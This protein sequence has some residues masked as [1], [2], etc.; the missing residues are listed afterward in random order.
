MA[1]M[2]AGSLTVT[3]VAVALAHGLQELP[4]ALGGEMVGF[5]LKINNV[6]NFSC[7][8]NSDQDFWVSHYQNN[9]LANTYM[10]QNWQGVNFNICD[11][12]WYMPVM[13]NHYSSMVFSMSLWGMFQS[14]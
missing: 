1:G 12:G 11:Q 5:A 4:T 7:T 3:W 2:G 13:G 8:I 10:E 9:D 14:L 6:D